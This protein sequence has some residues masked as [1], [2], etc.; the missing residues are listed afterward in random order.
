VP[1]AHSDKAVID[2]FEGTVAVLLVGEE[3]EPINVA[4]SALPLGVREGSWL[5][6][7]VEGAVVVL[8]VQDTDETESAQSRIRE[9]LARLRRGTHLK[10]GTPK[11]K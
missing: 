5:R 11:A 9:K 2:R 6:V 1:I 4:R 10:G 3:R 8:A 7:T